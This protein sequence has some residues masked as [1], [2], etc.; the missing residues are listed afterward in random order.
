MGRFC[1]SKTYPAFYKIQ[2]E[3]RSMIK[4]GYYLKAKQIK[5]SKINISPPYMREIWDYL[6]RDS[7]FKDV[8]KHEM[9]KAAIA[10][11][12]EEVT[13]PAHPTRVAYAKLI[14]SGE[15]SVR[16]VCIGVLTNAD[17][18]SAISNPEIGNP[19]GVD[20]AYVVQSMFNA[21]AGV[22]L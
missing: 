15:A 12:A 10:V 5:D 3:N 19:Y 13:T 20:L 9:Q 16:E 6:L 18:E 1:F 2:L 4:G 17:V 21:F 8:V 7:K 22:S 14:L 11:M